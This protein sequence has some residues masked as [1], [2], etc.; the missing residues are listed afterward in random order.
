MNKLMIGFLC[1]VGLSLAFLC[2]DCSM[3]TNRHYECQVV[4]KQYKP[5]WTETTASTDSDGHTTWNTV[6]HDEEWHVYCKEDQGIQVFDC[7]SKSTVYHSVTNSQEVTVKVRKG[8]WTGLG[9]LPR[10]E[11]L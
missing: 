3:G 10:I 4:D 11:D 5:P 1:L 6:Q 9:Y 2:V 7:L 8:K